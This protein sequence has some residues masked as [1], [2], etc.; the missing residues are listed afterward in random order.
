[1][2]GAGALLCGNAF[3]RAG[4]GG[5]MEIEAPLVTK[6]LS[7]LVYRLERSELHT[8]ILSRRRLDFRSCTS[9]LRDFIR[10]IG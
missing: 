7:S 6:I 3:G 9:Y 4:A 5:A 2:G 8:S 1:M 10:M